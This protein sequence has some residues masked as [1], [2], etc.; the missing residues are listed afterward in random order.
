[1]KR[2]ERKA[3]PEAPFD[4]DS[5]RGRSAQFLKWCAVHNL[6]P[7]TIHTWKYSLKNFCDWC[8]ERNVERPPDVTRQ[9]LEQYQTWLFNR[10]K[11]N[12]EPL[13]FHAQYGALVPVKQMF[14]W[15]TR[16]DLV[17]INPAS[18][19]QMP[20]LPK[21]LPM[22]VLTAKDVEL[23]MEAVVLDEERHGLRDRAMLEVLYST[24]MRRAELCRLGLYDVDHQR[25]V[26]TIR[27][28]K[29]QKDRVVP[30]GERALG[31]VGRY[32]ADE[33]PRWAAKQETNDH[34]QVLFLGQDGFPLRAD[35]IS[36]LVHSYVVKANIGKVGSAHLLRHTMA[37]L[38]L[39]GGADIRFIQMMLGHANLSTTEIYTHV[40][41]VQL[42]EV[43]NRSHPGARI[44]HAALDTETKA[45]LAAVFTEDAAN[46]A[47]ED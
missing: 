2:G 30:I 31:W 42:K 37:T 45:E 33:R 7:A 34:D 18:E 3:T 6:S 26:A 8:A 9:L 43:H 41:I 16:N 15:L 10:R 1:M 39:E 21:R 24:G 11:K 20:K 12:G 14:R 13:S 27:S 36:G 44:G 29:G 22:D 17:L 19:L 5:L 47:A 40:S 46:D 28:G 25:G 38:M 32:V 23:V 4:E 35:S